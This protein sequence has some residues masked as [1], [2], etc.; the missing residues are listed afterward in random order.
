MTDPSVADRHLLERRAR[1]DAIDR[2]LL[3]LV[4]RR[5]ALVA[6]LFLVKHRHH[7]PLIDPARESTLLEERRAA[8]ERLG[9]PADLAEHIFQAILDASH[10]AALAFTPPAASSESPQIEPSDDKPPHRGRSP[11]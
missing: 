7:L 8:A 11:A 2:A 3:E 10:A 4:A 6:D 1:I 5:R 9:V